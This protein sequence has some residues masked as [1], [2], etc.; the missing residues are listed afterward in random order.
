VWIDYFL[1]RKDRLRP[2]GD[3][4]FELFRKSAAC[5]YTIVVSDW[6][7]EEIEKKGF[8]TEAQQALDWLKAADKIVFV[9]CTKEIISLARKKVHWH[10]ELHSLLAHKAQ[11]HYL[12]TRNT[13]DFSSRDYSFR[14]VLPEFL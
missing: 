6:L 3:F 11:A 10:D 1:N 9:P 7:L 5:S 8:F 4:A 14:V 12:V 2:L 13:K